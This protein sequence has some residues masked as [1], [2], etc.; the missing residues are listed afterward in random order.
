MEYA[1]QKLE[2]DINA[3]REM[4]PR[5]DNRYDVLSAVGSMLKWLFATAT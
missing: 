3:F 2:E 4:L 1:L 5:L